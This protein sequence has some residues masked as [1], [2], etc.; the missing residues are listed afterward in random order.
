MTEHWNLYLRLDYWAQPW[1]WAGKS[2]GDLTTADVGSLPGATTDFLRYSPTDGTTDR[3]HVPA[4]L[5]R[6]RPTCHT[7]LA[8][9]HDAHHLYAFIAADK[10]AAP[11]PQLADCPNED[12]CVVL[13][14]GCPGRGFYFGM[15]QR[16][17]HIGCIQVWDRDFPCLAGDLP[18]TQAP[19]SAGPSGWNSTR[20]DGHYTARVLTRSQGLVG[21]FQI[22]RNLI[23]GD[24]TPHL[25][26]LPQG[27]RKKTEGTQPDGPL[28]LP[29]GERAGVRV[30]SSP[31]LRLSAGR[32]C[33]AAGEWVSWGSPIVWSAREDQHGTVRLV[34]SVR[35]PRHPSLTRVDLDYTPETEH[36][37]F[38]ASWQGVDPGAIRPFVQGNY[39]G[40]ADKV[41]LVLNSVEVTVPLTERTCAK[42]DV[43]D[44][45]NRLE[46]L[47]APNPIKEISFQ[48]VSGK[49][50]RPRQH[51][52]L[53]EGRTEPAALLEGHA[54]SWPA[55]SSAMPRLAELREAF[56]RWHEAHDQTCL[57]CGIWG[58]KVGHA[59]AKQRY[60]LC[61]SGIFHIEPYLIA[62]RCLGRQPVYDQRIRETC[63][64]MLAEQKPAGWYPCYC[65]ANRRDPELGD[66]GA[67]TN[68]SVGEGMVLAADLLGEPQWLDSAERAA[69]YSW[70]RLECNQNYAAFALWHLA[71]LYERDPQTRWLDQALY[72]ARHFVIRDIGLSGAQ[73]GHNF[74][75]AYG[76]IT[77]KGLSRLLTVLPTDHEF[78]PVLKDK[79]I[80]FANQML[81]RQQ[82]G[83]LF[84]G[85]NR[86]YLGYHHPVPG[87]FFV[88]EALPDQA[89]RLEPA[90]AA[91]TR[92][93]LRG[94]EEDRKRQVDSDTGLVLALGMRFVA[95]KRKT[96]APSTGTDVATEEI[97]GACSN[98][99][100]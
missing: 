81:S 50:L 82:P 14:T 69:D 40:Y 6:E 93:I 79:V 27:E 56:D 80:R 31:S 89:D 64:R 5:P 20:L 100:L 95:G 3:V 33:Y 73:G 46:V 55:S 26:P 21:C 86:K 38:M 25:N 28:P 47:T 36:G 68:G 97:D 76:N 37:A 30:S 39:A 58:E 66:G 1:P 29:S 2:F 99:L 10:P 74:F 9:Y 85:R 54:P 23:G 7:E 43:P 84:A 16:G 51:A 19:E 49:L 24:H 70:Y 53:Q 67:F 13:P 78:R 45:W 18:Q 4:G 98:D 62:S 83:G 92:A 57:A 44:G 94:G 12:F 96:S 41:T 60:C 15:N 61:H 75:T 8:I 48:K 90:L 52:S 72:L 59:A 35:S 87:L 22:N 65:S 11:I 71:A 63:E 77:L 34:E 32:V 88:A 42:F 17:E 91:M